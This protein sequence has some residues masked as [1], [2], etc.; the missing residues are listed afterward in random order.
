MVCKVGT[1]KKLNIY[2]DNLNKPGIHSCVSHD[3]VFQIR[4]TNKKNTMVSQNPN[5]NP[6]PLP[7]G[8]KRE[9]DPSPL[10]LIPLL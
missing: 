6:N 9:R 7:L 1:N 10:R 8:N 3:P 2:P 5:P 4:A